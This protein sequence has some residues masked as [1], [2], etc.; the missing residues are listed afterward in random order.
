MKGPD[1]M[2]KAPRTQRCYRKAN[3]GQTKLNFLLLR[4][5]PPSE[6]ATASAPSLVS[7]SPALSS[8]PSSSNL[9]IS[10]SRSKSALIL[11]SSS[12]G[13]VNQPLEQEGEEWENELEE[14]MQ[15]Q[16]L[17]GAAVIHSWEDL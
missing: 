11:P 17:D 1:L 3:K 8:S 5:A 6:A 10:L 4:S 12:E 9:N 2:S 16:P 13:E 15:G 7:V 14:Q